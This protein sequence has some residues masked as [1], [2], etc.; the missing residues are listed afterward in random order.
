[1]LSFEFNKKSKQDF[2][3]YLK[4]LE[5]EILSIVKGEIED[6][7]LKIESEAT[8]KV[9]V[10]TG[11]LK[12]SIQTKPIKQSKTKV[13]GG[14]F[15]GA[16]YAPYIEFGTGTEVKVSSELEKFASE[17][18]GKGKKKVNL[19]ARPFFYPEVFNQRKE[20]PKNIE[21][22]IKIFLNKKQ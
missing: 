22:S 7:L 8:K 10:D 6:S 15:V 4:G 14:V 3:K 18:K 17:F 13:E 16:K 12:N 9:A 19:M 1:M 2:F 21:K 11:A 5:G 20:L